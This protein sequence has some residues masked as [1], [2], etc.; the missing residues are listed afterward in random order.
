MQ[1]VLRGFEKQPATDKELEGAEKICD[2]I[3]TTAINKEH[4]EPVKLC[5]GNGYQIWFAIPEIKLDDMNRSGIENKVQ[6]FQ[7][8]MIGIFDVGNAID[9]IGDL[10]RIIKIW[11][12]YNIKGDNN[13]ER[14]YR[15]A[16]VIGNPS[17]NEDDILKQ[18]IMD[19]KVEKTI[20][21]EKYE[22]EEIDDIDPEKLP[23]C[24]NHLLKFY[25]NKDGKH[26]CR[27]VQLLSSFFMSIGLEREKALN[28][29]LKWNKKQTISRRW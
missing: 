26:W 17:R 22:I 10:P 29:I 5:S 18:K 21:Y 6:M 2:K 23:P 25:E 4:P 7:D 1:Y 15:V 28:I 13:K 24:I 12:S 3:I 9:K 19:M 27:I 16:K 14:P 8:R 20:E 11:G